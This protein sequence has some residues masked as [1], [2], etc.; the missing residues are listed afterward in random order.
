LAANFIDDDDWL[1]GIPA[2]RPTFI[3]LESFT[4]YL[5][6]EKGF[7]L[8]RKL[9]NHFRH[10]RIATHTTGSLT[11]KFSSFL[12]A[13]RESKAVVRWGVD[14]PKVLLN[15]DPRLKLLEHIYLYDF[16]EMESRGK[17]GLRLFGKWTPLISLLPA[18][19]KNGQF[20][21]FEF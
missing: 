18:Y 16:L 8:Y 17:N 21:L 2:D 13:L 3:I 5:Q 10:G 20:L 4:M 9:L 7:Q 19:R 6:P 12:E 14:D 11:V 15:L 1:L